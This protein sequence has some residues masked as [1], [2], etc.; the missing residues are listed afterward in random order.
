MKR[1]QY[2]FIL[3]C[4]ILLCVIFIMFGESAAAQSLRRR[5]PGGH[6][7][8]PPQATPQEQQSSSPLQVGV[9]VSLNIPFDDTD[10]LLDLNASLHG[11]LLGQ[12]VNSPLKLEADLGYWFLQVADELDDDIDD[13]SL[14]T[15]TGGIRY[16]LNSSFHLDG[17]L[18]L[19]HFSDWDDM[20]YDD[21]NELGL[22]GG[23]GVEQSPLDFTFRIHHSDFYEEED[24]FWNLG[25]SV[26]VLF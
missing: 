4:S 25:V 16:Y 26:R 13:P 2:N 22:Y 10:D 6:P 11:T 14:L 12:V 8:T 9:G 24:N 3:S 21:Q 20:G 17:G 19:Y 7:Q 18:G 23:L 5:P 1:H 15:L